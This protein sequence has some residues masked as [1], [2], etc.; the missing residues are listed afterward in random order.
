MGN[1]QSAPIKEQTTVTKGVKRIIGVIGLFVLGYVGLMLY[2]NQAHAAEPVSDVPVEGTVTPV[3]PVEPEAGSSRFSQAFDL[4]FKGDSRQIVAEAN[5][6]LEARMQAADEREEA[7]SKREVEL[8]EAEA[9]TA[10]AKAEATA[11]AKA[12]ASA[13][14]ALS[15]CV[16]HAIGTDEETK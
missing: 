10:V 4:I 11:K 3:E 13:H 2:Q 15:E 9:A 5:A 1:K 14:K 6:E 12:T 8:A 7:I 16:L